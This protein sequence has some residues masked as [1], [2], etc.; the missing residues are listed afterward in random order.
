[1][2]LT[3]GQIVHLY[4]TAGAAR[5]GMEA[6]NQEQHAL[7]CALLAQEGGASPELVAAALL[8][9]LGHL[10]SESLPETAAGKDDLHEYRA[11]PFLRGE[12]P[13]AV[14]EPIRMHVAAKRYLCAVEPSYWRGLSPASRRSLELQGGVFSDEE[15][16][17]FIAQPFAADAVALRLWDDQAKS[18]TRGTPGWAHFE[19]V[20]RS[21]SLAE[22]MAA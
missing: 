3:I 21:V 15:A 2:A 10:L 12:F 11:I 5:Y 16:R 14:I 19:R 7:Q 8:H 13:D 4:R 18:P 20:L 6:V 9:D 1:M 17:H 22:P